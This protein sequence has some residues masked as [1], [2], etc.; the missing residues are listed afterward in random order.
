MAAAF[1]P[2]ALITGCHRCYSPM[3]GGWE[4]MRNYGCGC[5]GIFFMWILLVIVIGFVGYFI[6]QKARAKT[7]G[8]IMPETPLNILK[9]RYALGEIT[10]EEYERMKRDLE[11]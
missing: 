5:G 4:Q 2:A 6:I 9:K 3:A 8:I 10:K 7:S 11:L 1:I